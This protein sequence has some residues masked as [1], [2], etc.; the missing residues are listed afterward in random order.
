MTELDHIGF[1]VSDLGT[2]LAFYQKLFGFEAVKRFKFGE[3]NVA[4][5][6]VGDGLLELIQRPDAPETPPA[7]S[8]V[9]LLEPDF[10]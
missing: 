8:H 5:L 9:A 10:D 7:G 4:L 2:S 6:G 3:S 1:M